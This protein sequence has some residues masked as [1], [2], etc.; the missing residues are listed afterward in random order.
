MRGHQISA[1]KLPLGRRKTA[2][3]RLD[4]PRQLEELYH[5]N[6]GAET[7]QREILKNPYTPQYILEQGVNSGKLGTLVYVIRNPNLN[8]Q[9]VERAILAARHKMIP[10]PPLH[11]EAA[12]LN[13][14]IS[15][16]KALDY[17]DDWDHN[18]FIPDY[19]IRVLSTSAITGPH[20]EAVLTKLAK[21]PGMIARTERMLDS[22]RQ[23]YS[24]R[25]RTGKWAETCEE[26]L[27][28]EH[29]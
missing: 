24:P 3:K 13:T 21:C 14:R 7:V 18:P 12:L 28:Y 19:L 26:V 6:A 10:P 15:T 20:R 11:L 16:Q 23:N 2:A 27:R 5:D 1:A 22:L 25:G 29:A 8:P 17:L 9:L 4:D